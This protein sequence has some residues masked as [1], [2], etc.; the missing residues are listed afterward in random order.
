MTGWQ[1]LTTT[2]HWHPSVLLG[3]TLLIVAYLVAM[4]FRLSTEALW[5][6]AGIGVLVF[7]LL[8]PV[9]ELGEDFLFSAH[10]LQHLLLTLIVPPLLLL[11]LPHTPIQPALRSPFIRTTEC[12]L[13]HPLLAWCLGISMMWLWHLPVLY[14]ATLRHENIHI[15][16][17]LCFLAAAISFWWPILAPIP[18]ARLAALPAIAYL[19]AAMVASSLLG[20]LLTFAPV[21]LYPAY[22]SPRDPLNILPLVRGA[23]RLTPSVDQQL[24]GLLM[25][26][27]GGLV[28]LVAIIAMLSRW[29]SSPEEDVA[30]R[31]IVD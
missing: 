7:T 5:Y 10:M 14:N 11:G 30:L 17:H 13:G 6:A 29:Y 21:G 22:L 25:W 28:Y 19:F 24:G 12:V 15:I 27:P 20:I 9:H 4:R 23:W 8:G 16:E 31:T 1:L 26:M 2:W 18:A 3:C